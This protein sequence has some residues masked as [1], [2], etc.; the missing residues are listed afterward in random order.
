MDMDAHQL[1]ATYAAELLQRQHRLQ[2][3]AR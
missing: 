3:E 2:A 1:N